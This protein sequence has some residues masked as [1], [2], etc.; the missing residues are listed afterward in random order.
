MLAV[1][2]IPFKEYSQ[3]EKLIILAAKRGA[4]LV[5]FRLD[6]WEG[7]NT[8]DF[9]YLVDL[10]RH[11]G[12]DV[13]ITVRD[14]SEGGKRY[15]NWREDALK[16]ASDV[17]CW[18]DIEAKNLVKDGVVPCKRTIASLHFFERP[19]KDDFTLIRNLSKM[20]L[21]RGAY[22]FKVAAKVDTI[23]ELIA[24][25]RSIEHERKAFMPMGTGT[26]RLRLI[27]TLL[28]SFLNYGSI[29]EATAPGQVR[30]DDIVEVI[31]SGR[32]YPIPQ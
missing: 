32:R 9:E 29:G 13:I 4:D 8:P 22:V 28:G 18:C 10:S 2:A 7:E 24:L 6:Y 31:K 21:E 14:P 30:L 23:E 19:T 17:N 15:V 25:K 1:A 20:S 11:Y 5:E 16:R 27:S 12:M 26:E 3:V